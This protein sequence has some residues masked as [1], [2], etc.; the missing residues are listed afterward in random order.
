MTRTVCRASY[1]LWAVSLAISIC[2][3]VL[4]QSAAGAVV[5]PDTA[6]QASDRPVA[7][8]LAPA[9]TQALGVRGRGP[10]IVID[11]FGYR[12][13]MRKVAV[14]RD[15][16][17][18]F[19]ADDAFTPGASLELVDANTGNAVLTAPATQWRDGA[20]DATSGDRAWLF[21]FSEFTATGY[22]YV[23]DPEK[24]QQSPVF[25]IAEE[26]YRDVLT[27]AVRTFYF[28]RAGFAK[29][30]PYVPAEWADAASHLGPGQDG[31]ARR[32]DAPGDAATARD[33]R[34][35]WY[36][37]GDYNKYTNWTADYVIS[38]LNT[39]RDYPAV[40][41]DDTGIAESGNGVPDLVDET[42]YGIAWLERMQNADGAVLSIVGL[43]SDGSPPSEADGP[44]FYGTENTSATLTSASAFALA[45]VV[46]R[47]LDAVR[48]GDRADALL[49]RAQGAW[50]WADDNPSVIFRNN[51][52]ASGTVGLGAGQ[53]EVDDGGRRDK[54]LSAAIYLAGATGETIYHQYVIDHVD[55]S[56]LVGGYYINAFENRPQRDLLYYAALPDADPAVSATILDRYK[57]AIEASQHWP[58]I[59][60]GDD[61]YR[62]PLDPYTWGS[63]GV[64]AAR[65][66]L[67]E[68]QARDA[69]GTRDTAEARHAAAGFLH[70]LHGVNPL[71]LVYLSN[72]GG[73]GAE[74]SV[75]T[76]YHSWF[77]DGSA[78]F[79]SVAESNYG[80]APGFLVG[81]P[82]PFYN[83][84]GCCPASCGSPDNNALC[85]L[86]A[87]SPPVAQPPKKSY[88]EFNDSWPLNSWQISE[89]SNG[90]QV[91]Y[92]RLLAAMVAA[93]KFESASD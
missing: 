27:A 17:V 69:I 55:D 63:N 22:Y 88:A 5:L 85:G 56:K 46:L 13:A 77:R 9:T 15:P 10:F 20:T 18:G 16:Q 80:P 87:P 21:D 58:K 37:A 42:L 2:P 14:L 84:D 43:D 26:V 41:G 36:D 93:S 29:T 49:A 67:F 23:R 7:S 70:Y 8:A 86:A 25:R 68:Q 78:L 11:Q 59:D 12:P 40:F 51:D 76:F 83:W 72:M 48:F 19:D 71:G 57:N 89:N 92:I 4:A 73:Y 33:L 91:Q 65:G 66:L 24:R 30:V 3:S 39:F 61:P 34:G 74:R 45:S 52:A 35:G 6:S 44:S 50:D 1:A 28:Q 32:Y 60:N 81:G 31:V 79:D 75:D 62:A 38:L 54:K 90:Y 47:Q 53:Q 64:T 82:N